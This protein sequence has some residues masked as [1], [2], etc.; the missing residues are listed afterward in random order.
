MKLTKQTR[1][2]IPLILAVLTIIPGFFNIKELFGQ[3]INA[4]LIYIFIYFFLG[5]FYGKEKVSE[6]TYPPLAAKM[7]F[8]GLISFSLLSVIGVIL[9]LTINNFTVLFIS[10][11]LGLI[12]S[13]GIV[14]YHL[15]FFKKS[16]LIGSI[17]LFITYIL[18]G[19]LLFILESN[20]IKLILM[21]MF[22]I[23]SP[24]FI[25]YGF[26]LGSKYAYPK[27]IEL[28]FEIKAKRLQKK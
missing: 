28:A 5:I 3:V 12:T 17:I 9:L 4:V 14:A 2:I 26:Y 21:F 22:A 16:S 8:T 11:A 19:S 25:I 20:K 27:I 15:Y 6:K 24:I 23:A 1:I 10:F 18:S 7:W 13:S